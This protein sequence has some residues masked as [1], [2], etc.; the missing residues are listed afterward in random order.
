MQYNAYLTCFQS[1]QPRAR[2]VAT[3]KTSKQR[4]DISLKRK[5]LG[6]ILRFFRRV[7]ETG[8][9]RRKEARRAGEIGAHA[10]QVEERS[11]MGNGATRRGGFCDGRFW[12]PRRVARAFATR[13]GGRFDVQKK[14]H[15]TRRQKSGRDNQICATRGSGAET[16]PRNRRNGQHLRRDMPAIEPRRATAKMSRAGNS[17][18]RAAAKRRP[19]RKIAATGSGRPQAAQKK[20]ST[21]CCRKP[22]A[23]RRMFRCAWWRGGDRGRAVGGT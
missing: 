12:V 5:S 8:R 16:Y 7:V 11:G 9:M 23:R 3:P 4:Y 18:H 6:C 10:G 19:A 1:R 13:R 15:D 17:P 20:I 14:T 2:G 21:L 22:E